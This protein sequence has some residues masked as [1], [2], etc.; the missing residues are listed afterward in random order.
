MIIQRQ[1]SEER[2]RSVA[3]GEAIGTAG[4][5][6][7]GTYGAAKTAENI[8]TKRAAVK[9]GKKAKAAYMEGLRNLNKKKVAQDFGAKTK[10]IKA[11]ADQGRSIL[12]MV[13]RSKADEAAEKAY[14]EALSKNKA[15][16][17]TAAKELRGTVAK[18]RDA[19]VKKAGKL[20]KNKWIKGG[21]AATGLVTAGKVVTNRRNRGR[22]E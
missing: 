22:E 18:S 13:F 1:F 17:E 11:Q 3:A 10:R 8:A 20:A 2:D 6:A 15:T 21:L 7:L 4:V 5:G 14:Q 12:D 16:Y 19:A 9:E